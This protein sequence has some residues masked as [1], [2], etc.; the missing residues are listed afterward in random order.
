MGAFSMNR[1]SRD[2]GDF[3]KRLLRQEV[4]FGCPVKWTD[5]GGC[6]CPVLTFHHFDPPWAGNYVHNPEGMIALCRTHHDQADGGLWTG[7]QLREM[8]RNPFIDDSI[9]VR[10]PWNP[11]TLVLKVGPCFVVRSGSALVLNGRSIFRFRPEP[12]NQLG[13]NAIVFDSEIGNLNGQTW[14]SIEDNFLDVDTGNFSDL[15]F[16]AQTT[17]FVAKNQNKSMALS[18][19]FKKQ[20]AEE[21]ED[22]LLRFMRPGEKAKKLGKSKFDMARETKKAIIDSGSVDSDGTVPFMEVKGT[23]QSQEA[24]IHITD[25]FLKM[26]ISSAILGK[27]ETVN[28]H[29][30]IVSEENHMSMRYDSSRHGGREWF[31]MG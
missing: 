16:T 7:Q 14:L 20:P 11:E 9:K 15:Y 8:K 24:K 13:T 6:G 10:W 31:R 28:F 18:L 3:I 12:I 27:K 5:G 2:P 30:W 23:F 1:M 26:D 17:K 21:I 4:N 19:Q 29:T 22:W 25:K